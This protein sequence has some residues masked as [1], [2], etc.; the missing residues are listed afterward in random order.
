MFPATDAG[1]RRG[2]GE[3]DYTYCWE[4]LERSPAILGI[5]EG[6]RGWLYGFNILNL[7]LSI[8]MSVYYA[9]GSS[10]LGGGASEAWLATPL[11]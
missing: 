11:E 4:R 10:I 1:A 9:G 5:P 2:D 6:E 3:R 8:V 7:V